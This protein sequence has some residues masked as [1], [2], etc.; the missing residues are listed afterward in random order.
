[1]WEER[2]I[3]KLQR[4][5]RQLLVENG[6]NADDCK[7]AF[8]QFDTDG[9]GEISFQEFTACVTG[10]LGL[11][12][13]RGELISLWRRLDEARVGSVG[14]N[15]FATAIF[16]KS[17]SKEDQEQEGSFGSSGLTGAAR[18]P[19]G[20]R[21][22]VLETATDTTTLTAKVDRL[23]DEV[24]EVRKEVRAI[25]TSLEAI[26]AALQSGVPRSDAAMC[27]PG[28]RQKPRLRRGQSKPKFESAAT[29]GTEASVTATPACR[30]RRPSDDFACEQAA[31]RNET[32]GGAL[33]EAPPRPNACADPALETGNSACNNAGG[34]VPPI[35]VHAS[36]ASNVTPASITANSTWIHNCRLDPAMPTSSEGTSPYAA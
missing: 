10:V 7:V 19:R 20:T 31:L 34:V 12:L 8:A 4:L 1:M 36:A 3:I 26:Q 6:M 22:N 17:D 25:H 24:S 32:H 9:S 27:G 33:K 15:Q 18:R 11:Q 28:V 2:Q 13:P 21:P 16:P 14:I 5:V 30:R 29:S 35:A 23:G